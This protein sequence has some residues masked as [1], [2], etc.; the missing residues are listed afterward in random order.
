M[1]SPKTIFL[2]RCTRRISSDYLRERIVYVRKQARLDIAKCL[3]QAVTTEVHWPVNERTPVG[4]NSTKSNLANST[5]PYVTLV[6]NASP[7]P[8]KQEE[9]EQS[10][11][12]DSE[13]QRASFRN[14]NIS[15]LNEAYKNDI[16]K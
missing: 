10:S 16:N 13:L 1:N 7:A 5:P 12:T 8:E 2:V 4:T 15:T 14:V 11:R 9:M 6:Q 3:G